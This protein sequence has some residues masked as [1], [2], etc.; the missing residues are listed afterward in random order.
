MRASKSR[1]VRTRS[2]LAALSSSRRCS[3]VRLV[4]AWASCAWATNGRS[5]CASPYARAPRRKRFGTVTGLLDSCGC[6]QNELAREA[7]FDREL[8]ARVVGRA[9]VVVRALAP[10]R[11]EPNQEVRRR[12]VEQ[13]DRSV[14]ALVI[15]CRGLK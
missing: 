13:I 2:S 9:A 6:L 1:I 14:V 12:R 8:E 5:D 11:F 15:G 7:V 4:A 10:D 3:I